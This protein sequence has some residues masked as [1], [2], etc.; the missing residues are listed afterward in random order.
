MGKGRTK[1]LVFICNFTP[2]VRYHY[3]LGAPVAGQWREILNSD[4]VKY[5]G[6]GVANPDF[7]ETEPVEAHFRPQRFHLTLPPLSVIVL[8]PI[9]PAS[10][11]V[12][13]VSPIKK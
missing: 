3:H 10:E 12:L 6:S 4:D 7:F 1:P 2:V 9:A 8:E 13:D 11:E 5:G